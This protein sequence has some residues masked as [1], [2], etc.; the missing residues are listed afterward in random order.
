MIN[1][2]R[3]QDKNPM[4]QYD[5]IITRTESTVVR[6]EAKNYFEAI[7]KADEYITFPEDTNIIM[8]DMDYDYEFKPMLV[9]EYN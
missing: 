6:V 2:K 7:N 3:G 9:Q 8:W 1:E 5:V 4:S